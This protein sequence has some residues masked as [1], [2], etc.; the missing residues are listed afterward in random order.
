M[1]IDEHLEPQ[2][3][4][5]PRDS[6]K[7][8]GFLKAA[9]GTMAA[10]AATAG[11][12]EPLRSMKDKP[13]LAQFLRQHYTRLTPEMLA[14][15]LRQVEQDVARDYGA[16]VQVT[17]PKPLDGVEFGYALNLSRCTGVRRCVYACMKENNIP[18]DHPE[19]AYI[20]VHELPNDSLDLFEADPLF[21]HEQVPQRNMYYMPVQCQQC[22]RPPCTA[23]CPVVA[24]WQEPDGVTV[25]DYNWCIGCRYCIAAC[26]YDAR[27]F[28][29]FLP[30][31]KP[32][33]L[34]PDMSY[35]G[36]RPR[37]KGVV[38]KCHFCLQRTRN[39]RN[40]ACMEVCPTGARVFGDIRDP[41]G[42]IQFILR[43]KRVY[44]LKAELKTFPRFYYFFDL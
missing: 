32:E 7:R 24:T 16:D 3:P 31:F 26:P 10:L 19:M 2:E 17:S 37:P 27:R 1:G 42:P 12:L 21:E 25:V 33:E 15:I 20:R 11:I 5:E 13:T 23:A 30:K 8:R 34:N 43:N 38:E 44:I 28:N 29:W 35:L 18:R 40:P 22:A 36:N 41:D 14:D 9:I 39:G 6:A 4:Q